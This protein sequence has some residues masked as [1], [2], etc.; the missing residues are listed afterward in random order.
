MKIRVYK[1]IIL[2]VI[3]Y[4]CESWSLALREKHRVRVFENRGLRIFGPE[5]DETM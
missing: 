5:R 2:L 1:T 3:L 4:G